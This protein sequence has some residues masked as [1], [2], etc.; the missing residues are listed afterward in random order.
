MTPSLSVLVN[1]SRSVGCKFAWNSPDLP[2]SARHLTKVAKAVVV[3]HDVTTLL[4][5]H[6]LF[7]HLT[8]HQRLDIAHNGNRKEFHS[9]EMVFAKG[10]LAQEPYT[11]F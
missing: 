1:P 9:G 10:D 3:S 2:S 11:L 8:E 4:A 7:R 6:P 5:N